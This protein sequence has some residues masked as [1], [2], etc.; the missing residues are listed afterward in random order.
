MRAVET[1][2]AWTAADAVRCLEKIEADRRRLKDSGEPWKSGWIGFVSYDLGRALLFGRLAPRPRLLPLL[3]FH[4]IVSIQNP[5]PL[6][7]PSRGE[8]EKIS[9]S[10]DTR[11][12]YRKKILRIQEELRS[13]NAYEVNLSQR[14]EWTFNRAPDAA[15]LFSKMSAALRPRYGY[16][17]RG[18]TESILCFSPELFFSVDKKQIHAEPIKGTSAAADRG[19]IRSA[20]DRA[21]LL[22]ITDLFRNDLGK[23]C[24]PGSIRASAP[25][26]MKIPYARHLFSRV[27]GRLNPNAGLP[28]IF[29][30]LFPS[31]SVTGAPKLAAC[32]IIERL[33]PFAREEAF[34]AVGWIGRDRMEFA[35]S[36]RTALLRGRRLRYTAGGGITVYSDPEKEYEETLIKARKFV[37]CL[38]TI[39]PP[40][41]PSPSRGEGEFSPGATKTFG[42]P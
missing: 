8:E 31:G 36:I 22:M 34:G 20:K 12:S 9:R 11:D 5:P 33:E 7:S 18:G 39:Y 23:I 6:S 14:W 40:S 42:R 37:E 2:T 25:V 17:E 3:R 13:G 1:L 27:Q 28:E 10:S 21:E 15:R 38:Q 29:A 26:E 4:K 32:E 24:A 16:L 35:V 19:L 41:Q 30:A